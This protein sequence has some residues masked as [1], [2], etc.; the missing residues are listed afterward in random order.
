MFIHL[1]NSLPN[2]T[3]LD[4]SEFRAITDEKKYCDIEIC[5]RQDRKHFWKR[6]KCW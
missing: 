2:D 5:V 4:Q 3:I 6:R 1:L